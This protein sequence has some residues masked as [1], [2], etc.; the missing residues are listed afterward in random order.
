MESTAVGCIYVSVDTVVYLSIKSSENNNTTYQCHLS[1]KIRVIPWIFY[2]PDCTESTF[3]W[4]TL[5]SRVLLEKLTNFHLV[6]KF[7]HFMETEG[8]L[9]QLQVPATC[10]YPKQARSSPLPLHPTFWT[11]ILIL[12]SRL[13]LGLP[14]GLF[15]SGLPTKTMYTHLFSPT[16]STCPA[17]LIFLD[18]MTQIILAEEYRSIRSSLCS[19]LHSHFISSLLG[20]NILLNTLFSNTLRLRSS[21][22]VH[23]VHQWLKSVKKESNSWVVC[24]NRW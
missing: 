16:H 24:G 15:P 22:Y 17:H 7:P 13:R 5:R 12:S 19:F 18:W 9:P 4:L 20:P 2:C 23:S 8:S 21:L 3:H 6:K 1:L 14:S 11:S 10:P